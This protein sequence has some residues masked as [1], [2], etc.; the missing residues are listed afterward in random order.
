VLQAPV[1]E[2]SIEE[3]ASTGIAKARAAIQKA[4]VLFESSGVV[5]KGASGPTIFLVVRDAR[6]GRKRFEAPSIPGIP[7]DVVVSDQYTWEL[8]W[9]RWPST[10]RES[11]LRRR[12]R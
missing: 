7:S 9:G 10:P 11:I 3:A 12:Q 6:K 4:R 8:C 5:T 2:R 1:R